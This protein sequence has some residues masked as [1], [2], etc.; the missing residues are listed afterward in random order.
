MGGKVLQ[1]S[2]GTP[3]GLLPSLRTKRVTI[4]KV[5]VQSPVEL[6]HEE[7]ICVTFHPQVC[8]LQSEAS[9]WPWPSS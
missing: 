3:E 8:I 2:S 4:L 7:P 9:A 5:L 1:L 6:W